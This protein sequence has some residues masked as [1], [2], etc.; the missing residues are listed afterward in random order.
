[1]PHQSD[2]TLSIMMGIF[3]LPEHIVGNVTIITNWRIA[4]WPHIRANISAC[5]TISHSVI[6]TRAWPRVL[7]QGL[8]D[9]RLTHNSI[10]QRLCK[11][12]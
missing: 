1:V 3:V 6:G 12:Q 2:Q 11:C 10:G 7:R 8:L 9:Y 5:P 4:T